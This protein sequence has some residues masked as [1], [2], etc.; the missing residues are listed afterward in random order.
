MAWSSIFTTARWQRRKLAT[1]PQSAFDAYCVLQKLPQ[2]HPPNPVRIVR[3]KNLELAITTLAALRVD[4]PGAVLVITGPP[5]A[6]NPANSGY[7]RELQQ[8]RTVFPIAGKQNDAAG[9]WVDQAAAV[10]GA[11]RGARNVEDEG[12]VFGHENLSSIQ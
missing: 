8:L 6:H 11:E 5:G 7:M 12:C 4:L 2:R 1:P 9:Q 3:R 10:M